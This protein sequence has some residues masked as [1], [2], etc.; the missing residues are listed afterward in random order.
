MRRCDNAPPPPPRASTFL[1]DA[2]K[3]KTMPA[4]F[5]LLFVTLCI[6]LA[7]SVVSAAAPA[8]VTGLANRPQNE[9]RLS[10][11]TQ[12]PYRPRV[13]LNADV[14]MVYDIDKTLPERIKT[15]RD[16]GYTVHVMTGVAWGE[17]QDYYFG[18]WDGKN[19]EDEAQR[20]KN[21]EIIG[22]GR[23][24]YYMSPGE[25]YG[26]YLCEG[27][28]R[29]LDAGAEAI[30]L[31]EPEYWVRAGWSGSFKRQWQKFYGE[32]WVEPDS[33][34]DAQYRAS[35][36]KYHLYKKTLEEV[37]AF[38]K[39]YGREH[40]REIKCYVPTHSMINYASWGIV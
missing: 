36:L 35:K 20:M 16:K 38:V 30:H 15:W 34:P 9:E 22:H 23:D 4:R 17:Y 10:F 40:G 21:G 11:Q 29:A 37:F 24:V 8:P 27:V 12:D 19:R 32:P 18:R 6:A 25:D 39:A 3:P 2:S 5:P 1:P 13:H 14:A 31:E 7:A 33:S 26:R 28:K